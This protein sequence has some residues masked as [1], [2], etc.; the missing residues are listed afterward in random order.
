[1]ARWKLPA[2]VGTGVCLFW[3]AARLISAPMQCSERGVVFH[4]RADN[5]VLEDGPMPEGS[6]WCGK[7]DGYCLC[8]PSLSCDVLAEICTAA[9]ELKLV[10]ID[11]KNPP[12]G[13]ALP[14]GY[15]NMGETAEAAA[16]RELHEETG[17]VV[18]E[19]NL[20][21][22]HLF[23]DPRRDNRRHGASILFVAQ[24][25]RQSVHPGDDASGYRLI[26][27]DL[28]DVVATDFALSD[29]LEMLRMYKSKFKTSRD[30]L[31][32]TSQSHKGDRVV[33]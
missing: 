25:V 19:Q 22:I 5:L 27:A 15:I 1:M 7:A 21:Q 33:N 28:S 13:L 3:M 26:S 2:A 11:R 23:T 18:P 6:C 31:C 30:H 12:F 17:L 4:G 32:R 24:P 8:T 10:L 29:H 9:G 20:T 14:G 16:A